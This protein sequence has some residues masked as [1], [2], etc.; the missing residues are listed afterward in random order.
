MYLTRY[1]KKIFFKKRFKKTVEI[2]TKCY[3]SPR[4]LDERKI[5][6]ISSNSFE[7][8]KPPKIFYVN[9][10]EENDTEKCKS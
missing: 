1:I 4:G 8:I 7:I 3:I 6:Y 10:N 2:T 5:D 9:Y